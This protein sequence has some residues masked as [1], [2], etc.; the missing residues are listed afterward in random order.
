MG[1]EI[2]GWM[3]AHRRDRE[4]TDQQRADRRACA[5]EQADEGIGEVGGESHDV[6]RRI[7]Q[8]PCVS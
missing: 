4:K 7:T 2:A 1:L 3:V 5:E 8:E 6:E